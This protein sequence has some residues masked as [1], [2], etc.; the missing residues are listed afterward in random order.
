MLASSITGRG[1]F[2][3]GVH[4]AGRSGTPVDGVEGQLGAGQQAAAFLGRDAH[5]V[6]R[7][8]RRRRSAVAPD[9]F[10]VLLGVCARSLLRSSRDATALRACSR[11]IGRR[12]A[13]S[14]PS[15]G[16]RRG[17]VAIEGVRRG[18]IYLGGVAVVEDLGVALFGL[19]LEAHAPVLGDPQPPRAA[20]EQWARGQCSG[21]PRRRS[22][23]P[24]LLPLARF[25]PS[26]R[27]LVSLTLALTPSI[28]SACAPL[29]A[30]WTAWASGFGRRRRAGA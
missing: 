1:A 14:A 25:A 16:L 11:W 19:Q 29:S 26:S 30:S 10:E 22:P 6:G 9:T 15:C 4:R 21:F 8:G 7:R 12:P 23:P 27:R 17:R 3:R 24:A 5:R 20:S 28:D 18:V 2:G 13:Y